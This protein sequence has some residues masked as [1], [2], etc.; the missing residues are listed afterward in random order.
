MTSGSINKGDP[1]YQYPITSGA[2]FDQWGSRVN[3]TYG[4]FNPNN[5]GGK[6]YIYRR[7]AYGTGV[8]EIGSTGFGIQ[9][10]SS[11]P[12]P[13]TG[14]GQGLLFRMN[15]GGNSDHDNIIPPITCNST[16]ISGCTTTFTLKY[17]LVKT[18]AQVTASGSL[19]INNGAIFTL[20]VHD[21]PGGT[22][23]Y[24]DPSAATL[25]DTA[26]SALTCS[27][28]TPT[29]NVTLP[30]ISASMLSRVGTAGDTPFQ[31][32]LS[33]SSGAQVYVT[34]TDATTPD[35]ESN[36]LTL[37]SGSS[38]KGVQLRILK[39]DGATPVSF[40]PDSAAPDNPNQWLVGDSDG[41]TS[42]PLTVQYVSTGA[43]TPGAVVGRATF[44]MSYQ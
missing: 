35:N 18:A 21:A 16:D 19:P 26:I 37:A 24:T 9:V 39:P 12:D 33:C 28:Q 25:G 41:M 14:N 27:V 40:G 15:V 44:T 5:L 2:V 29:I 31:I 13:G 38:A 4:Y 42:I 43:L 36:L 1:G 22:D 34:L 8:W 30:T 10:V 20:V 32:G 6:F 11:N 3:V 17:Y 7:I 23:T